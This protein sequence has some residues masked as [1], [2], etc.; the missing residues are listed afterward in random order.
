MYR[1]KALPI[2]QRHPE[3]W[4]SGWSHFDGRDKG[5]GHA[6]CKLSPRRIWT[7]ICPVILGCLCLSVSVQLL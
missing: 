1:Y 2:N 5:I 6:I 7:G 4:R 3:I